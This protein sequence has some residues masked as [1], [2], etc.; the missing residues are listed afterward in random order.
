[1]GLENSNLTPEIVYIANLLCHTTGD[2]QSDDDL[3]NQPDSSVLER[4]GIEPEQ[5]DVFAAK[6][7][8]WMKKLSDTLT[9]D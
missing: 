1:V 4:L 5:Y 3:L 9:F 2:S 7:R 6:T 8:N